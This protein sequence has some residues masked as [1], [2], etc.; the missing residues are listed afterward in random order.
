MRHWCGH[1]ACAASRSPPSPT[2]HPQVLVT[3]EL[4]LLHNDAQQHGDVD[5]VNTVWLHAGADGGDFDGLFDND[6]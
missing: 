3:P 4:D 1:L 6:E 5:D 2:V